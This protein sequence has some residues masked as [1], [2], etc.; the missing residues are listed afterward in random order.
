MTVLHKVPPKAG[1]KVDV[2]HQV[3]DHFD[4]LDHGFDVLNYIQKSDDFVKPEHP[5]QLED[6]EQL[7]SRVLLVEKYR[8]F[9][10]GLFLVQNK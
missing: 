5:S 8:P 1:V 6:S 9:S 10:N 3:K 4:Q 2:D 7:E